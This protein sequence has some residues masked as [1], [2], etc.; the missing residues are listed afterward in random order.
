MIT[1][2][3]R[4]KLKVYLKK[5]YTSAVLGV[6][7]DLEL[8]RDNGKP[9]SISFIRDIFN[10]RYENIPIETAIYEVARRRKAGLEKLEWNR[11]QFDK[12]LEKAD[13]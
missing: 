6:I 8:E 1:E 5:D 12:A 13:R 10:G 2:E 11:S 7:E 3:D 9:F 4:I